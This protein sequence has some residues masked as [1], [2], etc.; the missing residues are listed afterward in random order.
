MNMESR[1]ICRCL[2]YPGSGPLNVRDVVFV[3]RKVSLEYDMENVFN[4]QI[5]VALWHVPEPLTFW[6]NRHA[7]KLQFIDWFLKNK[8]HET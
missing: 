8:S 5:G 1:H 3:S 4:T 2:M 7:N 6:D